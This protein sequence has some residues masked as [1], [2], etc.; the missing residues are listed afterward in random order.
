MEFNLNSPLRVVQIVS[1]H[2]EV[3]GVQ[4]YATWL[5]AS[6]SHKHCVLV[7][8]A[9]QFEKYLKEQGIPFD[10]YTTL[11]D[12]LRCLWKMRPQIIIS[13]LGKALIL[14]ALAKALFPNVKLI[15][16]QHFLEPQSLSSSGLSG[17]VRRWILKRAYFKCDV[18]VAISQAVAQCMRARGEAQKMR[19]ILNGVNTPWLAHPRD[20]QLLSASPLRVIG[21]CRMA[22]EKRPE[23]YIA[24]AEILNTTK[25]EI[26]VYGDGELLGAIR[27]QAHQRLV[28]CATKVHFHG[29]VD[30]VDK[31]LETSH[32]LL[33]FGRE[34]F[35]F[36]LAE[37]QRRG[38][39][40]VAYAEGA[41]I[42]LVPNTG[43]V[44]VPTRDISAAARALAQF[45]NDRETLAKASEESRKL[46]ERY[47][48]ERN[49]KEIDALCDELISNSHHHS[50]I[51]R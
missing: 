41:S 7:R 39:P 47:S 31:R 36:V 2:D 19:V 26:D 30:D 13:H 28:R 42:E 45:N 40:V 3:A 9:P 14:G 11:L 1:G 24:V 18:I 23:D 46:S 43:G 34:A 12:G 25:I 44:L 35:G 6:S 29:Y 33:H 37:A 50:V 5:A 4:R 10:T 32:V 8:R 48:K 49:A 27:E 38:L 21:L 20:G 16:I 15:Y 51:T 17:F 22:P